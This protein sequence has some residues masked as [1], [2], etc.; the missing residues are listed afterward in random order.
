MDIFF[1]VIVPVYNVERFLA[2]CLDSIAAQS[3]PNY[4][5]LLIDDGS[6]DGSGKICDDYAAKYSQW[7]V[8]HKENGGVSAARN[9]ALDMAKGRYIVF[10]DADDY[11]EKDYLANVY[12][13]MAEMG[14]DICSFASRRVD[15]EG[16]YLFEQ[17]FTD[18]I[19]EW[20]FSISDKSSFFWTYFLQ[21]KAGWEACYHVF[22]RDI[23]EEHGLRF[24]EELPYAED[25]H[26]TF[27]YMLYVNRYIKIPDVMYSYTARRGS[28]TKLSTR[29]AQVGYLFGEAFHAMMDACGKAG[30][31][32][33]DSYLYFA[34]LMKYFMVEFLR[35]MSLEEIREQLLAS[36]RHV[37]IENML[38]GMRGNRKRLRELYGERA[39]T[40]LW[41]QARYLI[42][43]NQKQY[44]RDCERYLS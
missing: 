13:R 37:N 15:E 1:S 30:K 19:E 41:I 26:F 42:K 21:Y 9:T 34:A 11:I 29:K 27:S 44:K 16:N 8:V 36:A 6:G 28:A 17:R 10:V 7:Y 4:E 22:R 23:I 24:C 25:M 12:V 2:R 40:E 32:V 35:Y 3:C 43:G 18:M 33:E 31:S 20:D 38:K 14:Y 5:V 39:G